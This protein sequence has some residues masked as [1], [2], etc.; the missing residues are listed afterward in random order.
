VK[1][2]YT[3]FISIEIPCSAP[4]EAMVVDGECECSKDAGWLRWFWEVFLRMFLGGTRRCYS[5][6]FNLIDRWDILHQ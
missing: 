4:S 2:I 3:G 1:S 6:V 5:S